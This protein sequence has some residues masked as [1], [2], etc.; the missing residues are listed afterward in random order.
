MSTLLNGLCIP[1]PRDILERHAMCLCCCIFFISLLAYT[2]STSVAALILP[3]VLRARSQTGASTYYTCF[4]S[5]GLIYQPCIQTDAVRTSVPTQRV[6]FISL[7]LYL[8]I[9]VNIISDH[10]CTE[11]LAGKIRKLE[12]E[13]IPC[14]AACFKQPLI[15]WVSGL[16]NAQPVMVCQSEQTGFLTHV[17]SIK[18]GWE[19]RFE[20]SHGLSCITGIFEKPRTPQ[21]TQARRLES[22]CSAFSEITLI[23]SYWN[24]FSFP[25]EWK[26]CKCSSP[27]WLLYLQCG[28]WMFQPPSAGRAE[29]QTPVLLPFTVMSVYTRWHSWHEPILSR[30]GCSTSVLASSCPSERRE[31]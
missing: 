14:V 22:P 8:E 23:F 28:C 6:E 13:N 16:I 10:A 26:L 30:S 3:G 11:K 20:L 21:R 31:M 1:M 2:F 25:S 29:S 27:V 17:K 15:V 12:A 5:W 24:V 4:T 18:D 19:N 9:C 7:Y